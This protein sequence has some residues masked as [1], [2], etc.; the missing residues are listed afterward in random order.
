MHYPIKIYC[1]LLIFYISGFNTSF[2]NTVTSKIDITSYKYVDSN[3]NICFASSIDK[4]PKEYQPSRFMSRDIEQ[5]SDNH[6]QRIVFK[7]VDGDNENEI[8]VYIETILPSQRLETTLEIIKRTKNYY[9]CLAVAHSSRGLKIQF[10]DFDSDGRLEIFGPL[11]GGA[12]E[13]LVW[14]NGRYINILNN[15]NMDSFLKLQMKSS[16]EK[17]LQAMFERWVE[18]FK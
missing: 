13:F 3:G 11:Y 8:L 12:G 7:D 14:S 17:A 18:L 10:F 9:I 5:E 2:A 1:I 16:T 15:F 6:S 4:V